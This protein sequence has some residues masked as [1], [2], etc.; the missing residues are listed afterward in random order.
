[1]VTPTSG[2]RC[3]RVGEED[4]L[5]V[6]QPAGIKQ[7]KFGCGHAVKGAMI[8]GDD[9]RPDHQLE[10]VDQPVG[11]QV[12]PQCPAPEH[13]RLAVVPAE[14][15]NGVPSLGA[16]HDGG[17]PTPG[18]GLLGGEGIGDDGDGDALRV[19]SGNLALILAHVRLVQLLGPI[20]E[21]AA[22]RCGTEEE[23]AASLT[24]DV[25]QLPPSAQ[26]TGPWQS[27]DRRRRPFD[28]ESRGL[29]SCRTTGR[30]FCVVLSPYPECK[31]IDVA[32]R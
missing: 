12:G 11:Q 19:A 23:R 28:T 10:D 26:H 30:R 16:A 17:L 2:T 9:S 22:E 32:C 6:L 18:P 29:W 13:Q 3:D 1:M 14:P 4:D 24:A 7:A 31:G 21:H 5:R 25:R 27:A 15:G 8:A 20:R